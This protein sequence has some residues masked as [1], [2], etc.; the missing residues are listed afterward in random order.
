M[1]TSGHGGMSLKIFFGK[2]AASAMEGW[3][4][5]GVPGDLVLC[6]QKHMVPENCALA[7]LYKLSQSKFGFIN[8][9]ARLTFALTASLRTAP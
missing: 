2:D 6:P 8:S 5:Q 3:Q 1:C 7:D 9:Y 4:T